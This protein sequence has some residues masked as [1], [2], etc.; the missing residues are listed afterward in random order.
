MNK[1]TINGKTYN[2]PGGNIS[3]QNNIVYVDGKKIEE[4]LS[5]IVE[6]KF[7]GDLASLRTDGSATVKGEVKGDVDAGGSVDCGNVGGSVDA[8]GSVS[9]RDVKGDI[10]AGGSVS[11]ESRRWKGFSL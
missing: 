7:T 5:G 3:V 2:V 6:V 1:I 10:D 11:T 9:C 8:G 4:G